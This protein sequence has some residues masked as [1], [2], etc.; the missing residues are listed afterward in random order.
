M[1]QGIV[2]NT[3]LHFRIFSITI[4]KF[5]GDHLSIISHTDNGIP[6]LV[7]LPKL[8]GMIF[9]YCWIKVEVKV[10]SVSLSVCIFT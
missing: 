3:L 7:V 4:L 8:V 9:I 5:S 1:T 2:R 10:D 6:Y